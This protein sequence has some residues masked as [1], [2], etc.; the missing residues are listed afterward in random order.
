MDRH[1]LRHER[2]N[3]LKRHTNGIITLFQYFYLI[4]AILLLLTLIL[5]AVLGKPQIYILL[6]IIVT[7]I[8]S[9]G[10]FNRKPWVSIVI[11]LLAALGIVNNIVSPS[12]VILMTLFSIA[13]LS[14]EIYFFNTKTTKSQ[15]KVKGT[16]LF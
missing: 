8:I 15:L 13:F 11:T 5:T 6:P 2:G 4:C 9:Y 12:N 16:T 1:H 3:F 10:L 14:F 7:S